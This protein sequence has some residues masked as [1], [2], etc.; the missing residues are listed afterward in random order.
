MFIYSLRRASVIIYNFKY[1][2]VKEFRNSGPQKVAQRYSTNQYNHILIELSQSEEHEG[3]S[4]GL[5]DDNNLFKWN[6][7]FSGP[8]DSI[9]EV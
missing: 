8:Q 6:V 2:R 4:F 5:E 7:M 3:W 9:Y 1:G